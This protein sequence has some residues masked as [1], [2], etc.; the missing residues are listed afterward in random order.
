VYEF[1]TREMFGSE[2]SEVR[3]FFHINNL[4]NAMFVCQFVVT[5]RATKKYYWGVDSEINKQQ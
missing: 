2:R 5:G 3:A 4:S 1:E